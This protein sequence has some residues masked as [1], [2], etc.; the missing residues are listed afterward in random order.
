M[1][2]GF[3]REQPTTTR[4]VQGLMKNMY[5][6]FHTYGLDLLREYKEE[7]ASR[8]AKEVNLSTAYE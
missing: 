6:K 5:P 8:G 7:Q 4:E 1:Y 3:S 2:G